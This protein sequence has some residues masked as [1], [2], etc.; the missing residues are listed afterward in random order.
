MT[1]CDRVACSHADRSKRHGT[2][3]TRGRATSRGALEGLTSSRRGARESAERV[4]SGRPPPAAPPRGLPRRGCA[5]ARRSDVHTCAQEGSAPRS[6][7]AHAMTPRAR[8]ARRRKRSPARGRGPRWTTELPADEGTERHAVCVA[9]RER[10]AARPAG[11]GGPA[12]CAAR[13]AWA[14]RRSA[15]RDVTTSAAAR[16]PLPTPATARAGLRWRAVARPRGAH[17]VT[18]APAAPRRAGRAA[19]REDKRASSGCQRAAKARIWRQGGAAK[20]GRQSGAP[21]ARAHAAWPTDT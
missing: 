21:D 19:A 4:G 11:A 17:L 6:A 16:A 2:A 18:S 15:R 13:R 12:G 9:A 8:A 3:G 1:A 7:H 20:T 10:C 14:R 5:P